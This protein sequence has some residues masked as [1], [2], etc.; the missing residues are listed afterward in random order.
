MNLLFFNFLYSSA[1]YVQ[2][3][4]TSFVVTVQRKPAADGWHWITQAFQL[5]S[6]VAMSRGCFTLST[7]TM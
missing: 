7:V 5:A 3:D 6:W 2:W 4:I 1:C